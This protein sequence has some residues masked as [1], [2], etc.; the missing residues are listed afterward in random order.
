MQVRQLGQ[1][2]ERTRLGEKGR[3]CGGGRL[4]CR[5]G[6]EG[7]SEAGEEGERGAGAGA[8]KEEGADHSIQATTSNSTDIQS[9]ARATAPAA[10]AVYDN[11][12]DAATAAALSL[13]NL[14]NHLILAVCLNRLSVGAASW[15]HELSASLR[16]SPSLGNARLRSFPSAVLWL[17]LHPSVPL[18]FCLSASPTCCPLLARS[19]KEIKYV[20]VPAL[21]S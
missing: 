17:P 8:E 16:P 9:V 7:D 3:P 15:E 20:S 21:L 12:N 1:A 5:E 10:A 14:R 6:R 11:D 18:L 19:R 2:Q 13:Y 4:G